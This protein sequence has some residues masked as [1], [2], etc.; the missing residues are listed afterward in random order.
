MMPVRP[1]SVGAKRVSSGSHGVALVLGGDERHVGHVAQEAERPDGLEAG[2]G[3]AVDQQHVDVASSV[4]GLGH[5]VVRRHER[6]LVDRRTRVG[7]REIVVGAR[8][9]PA[10]E[11]QE[12]ERAG[13]VGGVG[14][15]SGRRIVVIAAGSESERRAG[16]SGHG[17]ERATGEGGHGAPRWGY[18]H[19]GDGLGTSRR[20]VV[21]EQRR[22]HPGAGI[23]DSSPHGRHRSGAVAS[24]VR[25][26]QPAPT[27]ASPSAT[28]TTSRPREEIDERCAASS[29]GVVS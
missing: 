18:A 10:G 5:R 4:P 13:Q 15:S 25:R 17:Q 3:V 20:I 22:G 7:R 9:R 26:V 8:R 29:P 21:R 16:S 2:E 14:G 24:R 27:A 6:D 1:W 23:D 19:R 11:V 28:V 12:V